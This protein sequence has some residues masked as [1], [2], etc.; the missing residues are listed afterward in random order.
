L[1]S[2]LSSSVPKLI[3][4]TGSWCGWISFS[5]CSKRRASPLGSSQ[6][7]SSPSSAWL[8]GNS[9]SIGTITV[10]VLMGL[11]VDLHDDDFYFRMIEMLPFS[12]K[13]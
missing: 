3:T 1:I 13:E 6:S 2:F 4:S 5:S 7:S 8:I 10:L 12:K 11:F 9:K